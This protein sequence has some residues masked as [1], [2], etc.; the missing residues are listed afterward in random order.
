MFVLRG[1]TP[2]P[3]H[4]T[5][6]RQLLA[7]FNYE[8]LLQHHFLE[9]FQAATSDMKTYARRIQKFAAELRLRATSLG[10]HTCAKY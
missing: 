8:D 3:A 4:V 6:Y 10:M 1:L 9:A 7:S 2:S 5:A